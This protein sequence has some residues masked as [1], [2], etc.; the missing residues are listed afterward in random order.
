[1]RFSL[2][3]LIFILLLIACKE[4]DNMLPIVPESFDVPIN[5]LLNQPIEI[6][7]NP[8]GRTP[9][10]A[11][12]RFESK[13]P[14]RVEIELLGEKGLSH[15]FDDPVKNHAIPILGLRS[16]R[17]NQ[18]AIRIENES[19]YFG[20]DTFSIT[21]APLP[22][23][24]P[25]ISIEQIDSDRMEP[26][27]NLCELNLGSDG[28]FKTQPILFDHTGE[29]RWFIKLDFTGDW[30]APFERLANGNF[31]FGR[32]S[33]I[34]EYDMLGQSVQRWTMDG[35]G[36]HH[37]IIEKPD[38][39]LIAAVSKWSLDTGLDFF[40]ELDRNTGAI[41]REW[42]TRQ[43]LDVDRFDMSYNVYDWL[44]ANSVWYD[45]R[46][47]SLLISGRNQGM[48][49]ISQNNEL[50]WILAAHRGWEQAG[51]NGDGIATSDYL[52]TAVDQSGM[53]Y[54]MDIQQ[55]ESRA[56]DFDWSW[57]QHA[58]MLLPNGNVFVYDNGWHR[59]FQSSTLNGYSRGVEYEVDEQNM[60]VKQIWQ[61]GE[62][63][64]REVHS[65]NISDVDYLPET[66]N[67][68]IA[69]GNIFNSDNKRG[70]IIEVAYP[71]GEVIFEASIDYKNATSTGG[72]WGSADL[73]YRS[74][75][76]TIYPK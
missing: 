60:T 17:V 68:L 16:G 62:E 35:L 20:S 25:E 15:S 76:L 44:H 53:P 74:E 22:D 37:D 38:G 71:S 9:L 7:L 31:L 73:I 70:K 69:P 28:T 4:E 47:G 6:T 36:Q 24:F 5:D 61:Y 56:P 75:R 50:I 54:E 63:R 30:T 19:G 64:G 72:G 34:Y 49:K 52:L 29:I 14:A 46:D 58:A 10:A 2:L 13:V 55:G 42:D 3:I 26:G 27:M 59:H 32:S 40:V 66:G 18:V 65:S 43:V 57:G 39:N 45:D 67:R 21:T 1:M 33:T 12:A 48:A 23:Y 8:S 51:P 11:E 41:V